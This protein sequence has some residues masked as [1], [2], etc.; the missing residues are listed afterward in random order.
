MFL[1]TIEQQVLLPA[2][3]NWHWSTRFVVQ[4]LLKC[5]AT[6]PSSRKPEN[7]NKDGCNRFLSLS[8]NHMMAELFP[9]SDEKEYQDICDDFKNIVQERAIYR[10]SRNVHD[11]RRNTIPDVFR[12]K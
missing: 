7:K 2:Q 1:Q 6:T 10:S 3:T 5:G 11:H 9:T 4:L 8:T 12:S